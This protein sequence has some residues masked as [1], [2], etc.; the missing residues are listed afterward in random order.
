MGSCQLR[1]LSLRLNK[2]KLHSATTINILNQQKSLH[3]ESSNRRVFLGN[4]RWWFKHQRELHCQIL[5]N[6]R[7]FIDLVCFNNWSILRLRTRKSSS[8][9][10]FFRSWRDCCL[11]KIRCYDFVLQRQKSWL[12]SH[13][14]NLIRS[15]FPFHNYRHWKLFH[16]LKSIRLRS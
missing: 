2:Q 14:T 4:L 11:W 8:N 12:L 5:Q 9:L 3:H 10:S 16:C 1:S 7:L 6:I 13:N 15:D